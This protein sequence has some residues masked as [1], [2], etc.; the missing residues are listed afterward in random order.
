MA[1]TGQ[2]CRWLPHPMAKV[3]RSRVPFRAARRAVPALRRSR[4]ANPPPPAHDSRHNGD[5][6]RLESRQVSLPDFYEDWQRYFDLYNFA[7]VPYIR[8]DP[9]GVVEEINQAGCQMLAVPSGVILGRPLIVF[10]GAQS[11]TAF[12]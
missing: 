9:N 6:G 4:S 11:R 5:N 2:Y 10:V 8:L 1:R 7:P 3:V 12:L